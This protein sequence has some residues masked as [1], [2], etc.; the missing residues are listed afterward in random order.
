MQIV[1]FTD[2]SLRFVDTV[3]EHPP[4]DGFVWIFL[5]KHEFEGVQAQIQQ[6]AL[7]LGGSPLLD[8]HCQDLA[9]PAHPSHYDSTSI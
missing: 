4:R 2:A 3:P 7:K 1:E 9:S 8:L 6:A 5:E